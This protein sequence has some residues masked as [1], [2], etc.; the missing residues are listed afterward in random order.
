MGSMEP[1]AT[2]ERL[3]RAALAMGLLAAVG[4]SALFT[5]LGDEVLEGNTEALDL[6][7]RVALH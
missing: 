4:A 5:W 7:L 2:T 1:K 6:R 3:A